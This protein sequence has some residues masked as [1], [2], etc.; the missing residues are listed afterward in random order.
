MPGPAHE[1]RAREREQM[2][3]EQ[4]TARGIRSAAVLA[5][6]TRVPRHRFMPAA[7]QDRAYA[8]NALPID[9]QQ[10]I[11]QPY[12]V[13]RMTEL[14]E[15]Q[16]AARVLEFGTGSWYQTAILASLA[17]RVFTIEWHLRLMTQAAER[18]NELGFHNV[19]Y[20][21]GDGSLGWVE[22]APFDAIIVTA[23]APEVPEPLKEQLAVGGRLVLPTGPIED[24]LLVRVRRSEAGFQQEDVIRCRFVK[25]LGSAGWGGEGKAKGPS[26]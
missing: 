4:L 21:C 7:L 25:L 24:Q 1:P 3:Q 15:L 23:G 11:S 2:V 8:D 20:R 10:T 18:L 5:A 12:M 22:Q 9:C 16:R 26:E 14:L 19:A 17:G 6:M 13:A